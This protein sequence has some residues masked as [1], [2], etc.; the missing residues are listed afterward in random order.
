MPNVNTTT[1]TIDIIKAELQKVSNSEK[2][3]FLPKFFR[4]VPGGYGEGDRFIGVAVPDQRKIAQKHY[5]KTTLNETA[6]MLNSPIHEHR[7]TALLMLVNKFEKTKDEAEKKAVVKVYL[8]NIN[9][10]NNWDLVDSSCY[11]ILGPWLIDNDKSLLYEYA[12]SDDLWKQRIAIIT[13]LYFI[14]NN[15]FDDTLK[16]A[17]ILLEHKHDLIH[18]AVG[19]MLREVGKIDFKTEYNFLANHYKKMPRTMLRYAIEKFDEDL[20]QS[21]LKGFE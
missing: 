20:R 8:E 14:K 7:L 3:A 12:W 6:D 15:Y 17:E 21:F 5:K 11:K 19:W 18:K 10:V 1:K 13:T 2:A 4:A 9:C 16:I